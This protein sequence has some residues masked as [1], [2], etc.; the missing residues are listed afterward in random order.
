MLQAHLFTQGTNYAAEFNNALNAAQSSIQALSRWYKGLINELP[1]V[2]ITDAVLIQESGLR[3]EA[4]NIIYD[5]TATA[6]GSMKNAAL[7]MTDQCHHLEM[8]QTGRISLRFRGS[9]NNDS[10]SPVRSRC[11]TCG[12]PVEIDVGLDALDFTV[13]R[14]DPKNDALFPSIR[15]VMTARVN[16]SAHIFRVPGAHWRTAFI[17]ES[18][19]E[20]QKAIRL[21]EIVLTDLGLGSKHAFR[22]KGSLLGPPGWVE[23]QEIKGTAEGPLLQPLICRDGSMNRTLERL[24]LTPTGGMSIALRSND[25]GP[26]STAVPALTGCMKASEGFL[27]NTGTETYLITKEDLTWPRNL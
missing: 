21:L 17:G 24:G 4:F 2:A 12:R 10:D 14:P 15:E 5:G 23:L 16:Q 19:D 20:L 3:E 8:N 22:G 11:T 13:L 18:R 9:R 7:R 1:R 26:F 27:L 6:L 25:V